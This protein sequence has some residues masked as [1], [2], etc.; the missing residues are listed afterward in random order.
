MG[1]GMADGDGNEL[2]AYDPLDEALMETFPAS[3][4]IAVGHVDAP[5]ARRPNV[6]RV[7]EPVKSDSIR[8][9]A[10]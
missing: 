2:E 7:G 6:Q 10:Q 4:P 9:N 5:P 3:D 1:L 8:P